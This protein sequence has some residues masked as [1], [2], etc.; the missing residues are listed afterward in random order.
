MTD[1]TAIANAALSHCGTRS[2]ITSLDEGS[3]EAQACLTHL[4][5]VRDATL[6]LFDWNFARMTAELAELPGPTARWAHKYAL[7]SD[8]LRLRRLNDRSLGEPAT[9]CELAA[10]RDNGGAVIAVVLTGLAPATAIY[11][12]RVADASRWDAGFVDAVTWG[13]AARI[14]FELTGRDDRARTLTQM[15]QGALAQAASCSA[16]EN[17]LSALP[18]LPRILRARLGGP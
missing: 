10:D 13:L 18:A 1:V 16:T 15:W 4:A 5:L 3:S 9:F 17:T 8:C 2:K 7:P 12:A 11:T 6:R 14:C